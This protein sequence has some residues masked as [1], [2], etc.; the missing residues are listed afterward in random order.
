MS[1]F[2]DEN[3]NSYVLSKNVAICMY[4]SVECI[5]QYQLFLDPE[6]GPQGLRTLLLLL[7]LLLGYL[8]LSD[9]SIP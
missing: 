9:Y 3:V 7:L 5:E 2:L 4:A 6:T 8:L 1:Q